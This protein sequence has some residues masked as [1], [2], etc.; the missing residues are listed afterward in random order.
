MKKKLYMIQVSFS[1]DKS[2]VYLPYA[3]GCIAAS[4]F[5]EKEIKENFEKPVILFERDTVDNNLAKIKDPD[6]VTFSTYFW[7]EEYNRRLGK[8][9][10]EAYPDCLII[11]GG[12]SIT[13]D[14]KMLNEQPFVDI[15]QYGEGE[16]SFPILLKDY[17][18]GKSFDN[19]PGA[20]FRRNGEIVRIPQKHTELTG[21]QSPYLTGIFDDILTEHPDIKFTM[22]V[23]TNRGC[24]YTCA[25]CEWS[26]DRR[27]RLFPLEKV[28]AEIQWASDHKIEYVYCAD[29]NFG[30]V[31]RDIEIAQWVV[32]VR[33]KNGYPMIFKPC[34]EKNSNDTV[35]EAGRILNEAGADK[36]ITISFQ[37]TCAEALKNIN[38]ENLGPDIF[39][40]LA[41]RYNAIGIPTYS[42]LILGLPGESFESF[43][44]TLC[45]LMEMGQHNSVTFHHCQVYGNAPMGKKE[46]QKKYQLEITEVPIDAVHYTP[47]FSG[48]HEH[49]NIVTGSYSMTRE[50][51]K[52]TNVYAVC[53][54]A[55]HYIGLVR[56]FALYMR[57]ERKMPYLTFYN[58]LFDFLSSQKQTLPGQFLSWVY[59]TISDTEKPWAYQNDLFGSTGWYF[60]EGLFLEC[61]Y[62]LERYTSEMEPFFRTLDIP[63]DVC[64]QLLRYQTE[65]IRQPNKNEIHL[66]LEYDFYHY[67]RN[68][69][70]REHK[71]L[72]KTKNT[73]HIKM[74]KQITGWEEYA[75]EIIW[76]GKRRSATLA[77]NDRETITVE[78]LR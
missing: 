51:W 14:S 63:K 13:P 32:D 71:P 21:F 27:L 45:D 12:H 72:E 20:M 55:F 73:L 36:G 9:I 54:E 34:Y 43:A 4:A 58:R 62:A 17:L 15:V 46:Y 23:E 25:Y 33:K 61:A 69:Y 53:V 31:K 16:L 30:I 68:I 11:V 26:H 66:P 70:L 41:K 8:R 38:R 40:D 1:F 48:V 57:Y 65:I 35:F 74:E 60:E 42:D 37:T 7:N 77:T 56:C 39:A 78:Y 47:N 18:Q 24:P 10:K 76:Y 5:S 19:V 44:K 3:A 49:F 75:R 64:L 6:V 67:F 52:K 2:V 59:D 28:K 50:E 29:S 22:T